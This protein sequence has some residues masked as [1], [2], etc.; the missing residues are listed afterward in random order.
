MQMIVWHRLTRNLKSVVLVNGV[1]WDILF[2]VACWQL[3]QARKNVVMAGESCNQMQLIHSIVS[4][5]KEFMRA[6]GILGASNVK[7]G[8]KTEVL[9][10][11]SPPSPTALGEG[12]FGRG[13][14]H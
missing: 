9:V 2:G 14:L 5:A 10:G 3:W 7:L 11:L 4:K 6:N 8:R 1:C 12:Q 13:P